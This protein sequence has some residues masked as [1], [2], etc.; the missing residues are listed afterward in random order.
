MSISLFAA[1]VV[2]VSIVWYMF[3]EYMVASAG[4][5]PVF[6]SASI[7]ASAKASRTANATT[8]ATASEG[9]TPLTGIAIGKPA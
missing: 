9:S 6:T 4:D 5:N 8:A 7:L 2:L 3:K 1:G